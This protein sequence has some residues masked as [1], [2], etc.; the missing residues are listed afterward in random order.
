[1]NKKQIKIKWLAYTLLIFLFFATTELGYT[2]YHEEVHAAIYNQYGVNYTKGFMFDPD[3]Y[4]IPT[5]YV[6]TTDSSYRLCNEICG[7]LQTENEIMSY[8]IHALSLTMW[9]IFI[10]YLFMKFID[11]SNKTEE[12]KIINGS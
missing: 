11:E 6:Q 9:T 10:I 12:V 5:Y 3:T 4:Y 8:N 2:F 1:M 7:S